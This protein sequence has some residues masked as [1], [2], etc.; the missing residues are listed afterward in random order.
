MEISFRF[1]PLYFHKFKE[2]FRKQ[3][4]EAIREIPLTKTTQT[5]RAIHISPSTVPNNAT[6]LEDM[7]R[8]AAIGDPTDQDDDSEEAVTNEKLRELGNS[9]VLVFGDL[10]T[11]QHVRSLLESRSIEPTPWRRMQFI[12]FGM[13]L[14]HL[15][16]A[17]ADAIW[18][19][20]IRPNSLAMDTNTLMEHVSQIRPKETGKIKTKP[21]FR[22]MHKVIQHVGIVSRLDVW[23]LAAIKTNGAES[24]EDFA[25]SKPTWEQLVVMANE[26]MVQNGNRK[27]LRRKRL[28]PEAQRDKQLENTILREEYFL[29]YKEMSHTLNF[30]DIG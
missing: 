21:G 24:L 3:K 26:I 29:L 23:R 10:L 8:Q 7:F 6:V 9:V 15:K 14:F 25:T 4:P 2:E 5:L 30:G 1:G 19:V 16:M 13:G 18:R 20:F 12:V 11:G 27:Q 22:C 17:C 28:D